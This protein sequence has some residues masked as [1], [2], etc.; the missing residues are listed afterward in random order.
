MKLSF[1]ALATSVALP[2]LALA[3]L[4]T[5]SFEKHVDVLT[6]SNSFDPIKAAYWTGLPHH[7]RTPFSVSSTGKSAYLAYLDSSGTDVH[8]QPVDPATFA[9]TGTVVT[10]TGGKEAGGLVA[11]DDGFALLTNEA[12]PSGTA[13]APAGSTPVPV[14][15]RFDQ[16]GAQTWKTFI[17]GPSVSAS[18]GHLASPDIN[19][20]LVFSEDS[21]YLAAY[22]V[23]TAYDGDANGH[24]GDAIRYIKADTGA[25]ETINGASSDWG[26]SHN[27]GIAFEA[28]ADPPFASICAEDQGAIWLN[29]KGQGMTTVGVKISNENVTNGASNE[30]MGGMSGSYSNLAR[31]ANGT[32]YIFAWVS[33]GAV[34]LTDNT[35]MGGGYVHSSN[36][37]NGRRV[38]VALFSDKNTLVGPQATSEVG[39]KDGDSQVNFITESTA[40]CSNAHA[41]T[42]DASNALVTWEEIASPQ[43]DFIAMGCRGTFSGS[44][45]QQVS[46]DGIKVGESVRFD[47]VYVAGDM[48]TMADGKV[49][50]PYVSGKWDL[51][52][53]VG[54][55]ASGTTT[56]KISFACAS[57]SGASGNSTQN[58]GTGS[59]ETSMDLYTR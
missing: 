51:D 8:I 24:F 33:R 31:F 56:T 55:G 58:P 27:T 40:D 6:L 34:D 57:L 10:V 45:F 46:A 14:V 35:W 53:T 37:T 36:R 9:A 5:D 32:Q 43:C 22:I 15:Y 52:R 39:A 16:S 38:A 11:F 28:A 12:L 17:G 23:V 20:D 25:L 19:G 54:D 4:T 48:V 49:C 47:D 13:N 26:C 1:F 50:W 18:L 29:T 7:R 30:P 21:G 44:F 2:S 42:F 41:A 3:D 59:S